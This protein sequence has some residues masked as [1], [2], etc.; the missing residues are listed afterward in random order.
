MGLSEIPPPHCVQGANGL[1]PRCREVIELLLGRALP[2]PDIEIDADLTIGGGVRRTLH[3][4]TEG[5]VRRLGTR[6][7]GPRLIGAGEQGIC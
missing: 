1:H 4:D 6:A 2:E 5:E 3:P 7:I